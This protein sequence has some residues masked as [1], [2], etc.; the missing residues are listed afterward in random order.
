[1]NWIAA[2]YGEHRDGE[3]GCLRDKDL[4]SRGYVL[5]K[6]HI[7]QADLPPLDSK[8]SSSELLFRITSTLLEPRQ[9]FH[10]MDSSLLRL[11]VDE[12]KKIDWRIST[13]SS[14][15]EPCE[16]NSK[17]KDLAGWAF[18]LEWLRPSMYPIK[19]LPASAW[20][21]HIPFLFCLIAALRPRRYVELGVHN[22]GS[23][24]A[25]CQAYQDN[26]LK[27]RCIAV[28]SWEGDKHAGFHDDTVFTDFFSRLSKHFSDVGSYI[29]G[30]FNEV[31]P[32]FSNES[33]DI[34]HIDGLHTYEAVSN[35][36]FT[37][38]D[39][40]TKEGVVLFHDICEYRDD[41]GVWSF[42]ADL[43]TQYPHLEFTHSHGLGVLYLGQDGNSPVYRLIELCKNESYYK[44]LQWFFKHVGEG[45]V[46]YMTAL[47]E[48]DSAL[49][50]RDKALRERDDALRE[51]DAV[52]TSVYWRGSEPIR[53]FLADHPRL[54]DA[55]RRIF[56]RMY[57]LFSP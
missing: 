52:C 42:W 38:K 57:R 9:R 33:I 53:G 5:K 15:G 39:K 20:S 14:L 56:E 16:C 17:L 1:L 26:E 21:G 54:R 8:V 23:F 48:R 22:G 47:Q 45:S 30:D 44:Y 12:E 29:K 49:R 10:E 40:L 41:F 3:M 27:G 13:F 18:L 50:G 32:Y 28:D 36:Y 19:V 46:N 6:I 37:W 51:R 55:L 24:F 43:K 7:A 2:N 11:E 4:A 34:L 31:A 25:A 35:D